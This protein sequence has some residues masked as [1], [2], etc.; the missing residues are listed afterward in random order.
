MIN[1]KYTRE[2]LKEIEAEAHY[3]LGRVLYEGELNFD[4]AVSEL[5]QAV[6]MDPQ[7]VA[8]LYHLGQ[9]IRAQVE[10]NNEAGGGCCV[11]TC[12]EAKS[13]ATRRTREFLGARRKA[14][15]RNA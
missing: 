5:E 3:H 8:A 14:G 4:G 12:S 13:S 11:I 9:A 7:N 6:W 15:T 2:A 1:E 10:R